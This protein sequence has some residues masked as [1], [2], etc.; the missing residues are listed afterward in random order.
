MYKGI[1]KKKLAA[2]K[3]ESLRV[4]ANNQDEMRKLTAKNEQGYEDANQFQTNLYE[5][6]LEHEHESDGPLG[7][8]HPGQC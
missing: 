6:R 1:M 7:S 3:L 4:K 2:N 8:F 5:V